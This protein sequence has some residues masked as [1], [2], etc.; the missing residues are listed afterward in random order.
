MYEI[1]PGILEKEWSEI[2]KKI[3]IVRPFA[4]TIHIDIIDGKFADN[5][6]FL[7]PT[8]FKQY[9]KDFLF[10]LHMMVEEP[11]NYI[12]PWAEV[13]FQ[14][15]IGHVEK[16]SDQAAFITSAEELGEAGLAIDGPTSLDALKISHLDL[17]TLL[18][19][20]IK[21]GF[22]GQEFQPQQLDKIRTI[23][24]DTEMF[25][26]AVD[27]GITEQT[28]QDAWKAGVRR[29][30]TTHAL[31]STGDPATTY[32]HFREICTSLLG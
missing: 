13:G 17:D 6:T 25:T 5:N 1:V 14:R 8:P 11:I 16:M 3:E 19:M 26:I 7:D 30:I 31:F 21:A 15:F 10:E 29:F 2:A 28:L 9:T 12:K 32:A 22:S 20:T 23:T 18:I 24:K 27:G 4:K